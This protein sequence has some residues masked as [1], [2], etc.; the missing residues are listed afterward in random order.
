MIACSLGELLGLGFA[1]F[2]AYGVML[3]VGATEDPSAQLL[4]VLA[5][6]GA[7][8]TEGAIT[9]T[10]QW[11]VL[12]ERYAGLPLARFIALTSLVAAVGWA[13]GMIPPIVHSGQA[14]P[15]VEPSMA[16]ILGFASVFGAS[17]GALFG[18]A[19]WIVLRAHAARAARWIAANAIGWSIG[20]PITYVG[21]S[22][23]AQG[24]GAL[25]V[26]LAG[27]LSGL[28]AGASVALATL[29]ALRRMP[30]RPAQADGSHGLTFRHA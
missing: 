6:I 3:R 16:V 19:Q 28:L 9:A 22:L 4:V 21:G 13:V 24:R 8:A 20:L 27:A 14:A 12:V 25:P 11:R 1:A 23:P 5:M 29:V 18:V 17:A 2:V 10:L 26:V 7:G 30:A 15:V